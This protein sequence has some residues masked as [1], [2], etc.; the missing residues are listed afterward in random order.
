MPYTTS[1]PICSFGCQTSSSR[2]T[3]ARRIA[4]PHASDSN[5]CKHNFQGS[6]GSEALPAGHLW[7][8]Q[9]GLSWAVVPEWVQLLLERVLTGYAG[10]L[11]KLQQELLAAESAN[12]GALAAKRREALK[13]AEAQK[14]VL[15]IVDPSR[16]KAWREQ[17]LLSVQGVREVVVVSA[18][19]SFICCLRSTSGSNCP[20]DLHQGEPLLNCQS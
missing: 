12:R 19:G 1:W 18:C 7:L 2:P 15:L 3:Q 16:K 5:Y 20:D 6:I 10:K 8:V 4:E 13:A 14:T 9:T 11:G 17:Q